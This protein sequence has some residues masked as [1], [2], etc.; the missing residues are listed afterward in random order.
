MNQIDQNINK[1]MIDSDLIDVESLDFS[2]DQ[3][4]L[5]INPED[6]GHKVDIVE[7]NLSCDW[8]II[9]DEEYL[10]SERDLYAIL[11]NLLKNDVAMPDKHKFDSR[12][13]VKPKKRMQ[14]P[15]IQ[16]IVEVTSSPHSMSPH[17][18]LNQSLNQSAN[19]YLTYNKYS[20]PL[21]PI[22]PMIRLKTFNVDTNSDNSHVIKEYAMKRRSLA[23]DDD[24]QLEDLDVTLASDVSERLSS[25]HVPFKAIN[26][27]LSQPAHN[28]HNT[29]NKGMLNIMHES[30]SLNMYQ[31]GESLMR[32]SPP[33]LV[34]SLVMENSGNF[35]A[36]SLDSRKSISQRDSGLPT[37]V[38]RDSIDPMMTSMTLSILDEKDMSTSF[39]SQTTYPDND[40][41]MDSLPPSLV[42]SVN[43]SYVVSN[44]SKPKP[45]NV[46]PN[47]FSSATFTHLEQSERLL[48]ARPR[49]Q[50]YNSFTKR[51]SIKNS[52]SYTKARE[53]ACQ[54]DTVK[55]LNENCDNT[56]GVPQSVRNLPKSK[57]NG[58]MSETITLHYSNNKF[59]R[60]S[61]AE[62]ENLNA[63]FK[64]DDTFYKDMGMQK[65]IDS[66]KS[67]LNV[68]LDKQE[69]NEIIQARQK[70]SLARKAL[71]SDP[72]KPN[73]AD[74]SPIKTIQL[75][76][77][78]I[79]VPQKSMENASELL[80]RRRAMNYDK[81]DEERPARETPKRN[82]T[83]KK[84]SPKASAMDATVV[85]VNS[86]DNNMIDINS[87]TLNLIDSSDRTLQQEEWGFQERAM[88]GSSESTGTDTCTFSSS[89]P[90]ES[91]PE[92]SADPR[93]QVASTPL[94]SFK[95]GAKNELL[96]LHTTISPIY[97]M[98]EDKSYTVAKAP[99]AGSDME[100][101]YNMN[102]TV[103][104]TATMVKKTSAKR[105][106]LA[107]KTSPEKK[108]SMP[109]PVQR[110]PPSR[111][112]PTEGGPYG[113]MAPPSA[114]P[115]KTSL[116]TSKLRQYSSHKELNRIP[117][118]APPA[119][120]LA[121]R[122]MLRRGVY[123]SNPALSPTAPAP[124][125]PPAPPAH[126]KESDSERPTLPNP[127][128]LVR[129][130]T[131]TLRR[132]RPQSQLVA[133]R[134]L[135]LSAVAARGVPVSLRNHYAPPPTTRPYSIA[136]STTLRISRPTSVP[137]QKPV[138][139][140]TPQV[141][142][143]RP[144]TSSEPRMSGLPRPSRLPAP[145]RALRPPSVYSVA[146]AGEMDH[147]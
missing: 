88:V 98:L 59:K 62:K 135:R 121:G 81:Q 141:E 80:S 86:D 35:N 115:R 132:E 4:W 5:Y 138:P 18:S 102:A 139:V 75:P 93:I 126:R 120:V 125:A 52:E 105:D 77:Q 96:N 41:L 48:S 30:R 10:K 1:D 50:L 144:A 99:S 16:S 136:G 2:D 37:S 14:R 117:G 108:M 91:V 104:N 9:E 74:V 36:E 54:I 147:Y 114:V 65:P 130:G 116:P 73:Q 97:D 101:T 15:S 95:K 57:P 31:S 123:A 94:M 13:Y 131:E 109:I 7:Y 12:T 103:I 90:P 146:P 128:A 8:P 58:E 82:A 38:G 119:R 137:L 129:Q 118:P 29:F 33:S 26:I 78:T 23:Q 43:S 127:P 51:D 55:V 40:S 69:L 112:S 113:V 72:E 3:T 79:T 64:C 67:S 122:S 68:T 53:E 143:P 110:S 39:L 142:Q 21:G 46:E 92:S 100:R 22:N 84:V 28:I 49:C 24:P 87:A 20:N 111:I 19:K 66:G 42:S 124:P 76:N 34:S 11:D 89:S 70:L 140:I 83:F 107:P 63:K 27:D 71:P 56:L 47:I 85:Y 25:E 61:D 6:S 106:I 60:D 45:D 32:M 133:P 134:D 145:R 44:T 17:Q